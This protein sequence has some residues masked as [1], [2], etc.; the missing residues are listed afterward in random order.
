MHLGRY[1]SQEVAVQTPNST[2]P[3][4]WAS[5]AALALLIAATGCQEQVVSKSKGILSVNP[6]AA[7]FGMVAIGSTATVTLN[8]DNIGSGDLNVT[9][10]SLAE[11]TDV[12]AIAEGFSGVVDNGSSV[13]IQV[14]YSPVEEADD[15]ATLVISS[16]GTVDRVNVAMVGSGRDGALTAYPE[17]IDF[18]PVDAGDT[19]S[20]TVTI[21]N[22]G[23]VSFWI[24]ELSVDTGSGAFS[25]ETDN[26]ELPRALLSGQE[27]AAIVTFAPGDIEPDQG[28][29][30]V[31]TDA[32]ALLTA[33]VDLYGN[34]CDATW[35]LGYDGDG[36]GY[37]V[38]VDDCDDDDATVYPGAEEQE[39]G[40]DN[41]CDGI[42]DN[43]TDSYDDDGDG[44]SEDDGDCNDGD[45]AVN[46]DAEEVGNG[47]DDDCDGI[48]DEGTSGTDDDGDGYAEL[49]GD[50]DDADD[51]V[52]PGAPELPDEQDNDCDGVIDEG[53]E[54]VDDDGDGFS[55]CDGDCDGDGDC[56]GVGED[57]Q[58][59]PGIEED[60]NDADDDVYP[61]APDLGPGV[62][63]DCS[64]GGAGVTDGDL[65]GYGGDFG[66][67][68][69]T[70][71]T[72]YPG[73][74]ELADGIDNDC[75]G[76]VD[77]GTENVDDDGDG[78]TELAGDCNDADPAIFTGA[79]EVADWKDNDCDGTVDEGTDY[80]DDDGDGAT[81]AG[82]DCDD[83]DP[84][85][86]PHMLE[87]P[88]N[89]IDDDCDGVAD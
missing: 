46:P 29:L 4:R 1:V 8:L 24:T 27:M 28:T 5:L 34:D 60:C 11:S 55:E 22:D 74:P 35:S 81:E 37:S 3:G 72:V 36:D 19:P 56:T 75:D 63:W 38:C 64:G 14:A 58:G 23:V 16:D 9:S 78:V 48:I 79:L 13:Q 32:G 39:D 87:I 33:T 6:G 2:A 50:C 12:F 73:A 21:R 30:V 85:V 67:C 83:A 71:D 51:T 47:F 7:H 41:D 61:G 17:V 66:D 59:N 52:Y 65:D 10:I 15:Q 20:R 88:G 82:G 45:A 84:D 77:E 40:I 44:F 76:T 62:D 69:D 18:G 68:D 80:Y 43:D 70:D 31:E 86:G 42:V 53:T 26:G 89:G 49:G 57:A 25:A 54:N